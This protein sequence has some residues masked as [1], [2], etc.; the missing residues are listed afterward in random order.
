[1]FL[2][3]QGFRKREPNYGIEYENPTLL[4][5]LVSRFVSAEP[6]AP[7]ALCLSPKRFHER[8]PWI[9]M[10]GQSLMTPTVS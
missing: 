5:E 1:M 8:Y 4:T 3:S 7:E 9:N 10:E 2:S 6:N